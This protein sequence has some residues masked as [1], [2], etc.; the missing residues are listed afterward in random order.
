MIQF[1]HSID[2]LLSKFYNVQALQGDDAIYQKVLFILD[3][4]R[5]YAKLTFLI[6]SLEKENRQYDELLAKRQAIYDIYGIM[7][8]NMFV[9]DNM[10]KLNILVYMYE[11]PNVRISHDLF[12]DNEYIYYD[13]ECDCIKDEYN[14]IFESWEEGRNIYN[15]FYARTGSRWDYGWHL[16]DKDESEQRTDTYD[17]WFN[18]KES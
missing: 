17:N 11:H 8:Y 13:K 5:E 18:A 6:H 7:G 9:N 12:D 10:S 16:Y 3:I 15:G 14:N 2:V 1:M 4:K